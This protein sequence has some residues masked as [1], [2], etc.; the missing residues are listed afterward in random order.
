VYASESLKLEKTMSTQ[1]TNVR[2]MRARLRE[3]IDRAL[4]GTD[5]L[6]ERNGEPVAVLISADDYQQIQEEL[7]TM[8]ARRQ[9]NLDKDALMDDEELLKALYAPFSEEE[10]ALAEM[11]LE[12][13]SDLLK[14]E[15]G[16]EV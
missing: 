6:I 1:T 10:Q 4:S 16:S 11:G 9:I 2:Q 15:E 12:H 3:F 13:Y 7:E 5:V 14:S 8:R